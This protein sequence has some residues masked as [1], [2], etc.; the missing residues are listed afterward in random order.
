M[1]SSS[2]LK[3][4]GAKKKGSELGSDKAKTPNINLDNFED[5]GMKASPYILTSPR[6]L[7]VCAEHNVQPV[8][9]LKI[10]IHSFT[11]EFGLKSLSKDQIKEQFAEYEKKRKDF[12]TVVRGAR[13]A[14]VEKE[15][16]Q[17]RLK[18]E[19]TKQDSEKQSQKK[20]E[21]KKKAKKIINGPGAIRSFRD[22]IRGG[23]ASSSASQSRESL[24]TITNPKKN[25]KRNLKKKTSFEDEVLAASRDA[26]IDQDIRTAPARCEREKGDDSNPDK[27]I[28]TEEHEL[29]SEDPLETESTASGNEQVSDEMD[30]ELDMENNAESMEEN[31]NVEKDL[32]KRVKKKRAKG[33]AQSKAAAESRIELLNYGL[34]RLR[35]EEQKI[36]EIMIAKHHLEEKDKSFFRAKTNKR[37]NQSLLNRE[38][39]QAKIFE[40]AGVAKESIAAAIEKETGRVEASSNSKIACEETICEDEESSM[41]NQY[42]QKE[43]W[44]E[45]NAYGESIEKREL[46]ALEQKLQIDRDNIQEMIK[47]EHKLIEGFT[48]AENAKQAIRNEKLSK[49]KEN[50]KERLEFEKR[51]L[52]RLQEDEKRNQMKLK[53]LRIKQAQVELNRKALLEVKKRERFIKRAEIELR[54]KKLSEELKHQEERKQKNAEN[55][56]LETI[57]KSNRASSTTQELVRQKKLAAAKAMEEKEALHMRKISRIE[58]EREKEEALKRKRF[59]EKLQR[60]TE[61]GKQKQEWVNQQ[62]AHA[63]QAQARREK[64]R[65]DLGKKDFKKMAESGKLYSG[66]VHFKGRAPG[67]N[68]TSFSMC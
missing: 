16:L 26:A 18:E 33:M 44:K 15:K 12:L 32:R 17:E 45:K 31:A 52:Q 29:A 55:L 68:Q 40:L 39:Q 20:D 24:N 53:Q 7:R 48:K 67:E 11:A 38:S 60:A 66:S 3:R 27:D 2:I 42:D 54:R 61:F 22:R 49:S 64:L 23:S 4:T 43:V 56:V 14:L 57:A 62:R 37:L 30:G 47:L 63:L 65:L 19:K 25:L 46:K 51:H 36:I 59:E 34:E 13:I 50:E 41:L 10:P 9:L 5:P 6:S 21:K 1:S 58:K 28:D 8:D 35:K